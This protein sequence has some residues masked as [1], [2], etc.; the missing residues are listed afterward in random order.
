MTSPYRL[1]GPAERRRYWRAYAERTIPA[2]VTLALIG[3][4]T[5]PLFVSV[6]AV[7]DFALLAVFVWA[8][9]QPGLMPPWLAFAIGCVADLLFALPLGVHA[10]L[11]PVTVVVVRIV[12]ARFADHRYAFDWLFAALVIVG[13]A[14]LG[15]QLL[16]I[17]GV[18][19]PLAPLLVQAGTTIL[20]YP[21]VVG[22]M[23]AIQRRLQAGR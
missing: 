1:L 20:A 12:D 19:G 10:T 7:P 14:V 21:A 3:A 18:D 22:L 11:L 13:F 5:A 8:S 4:M 6:P 15:W 16:A 2:L 17:A 9:F 23:A